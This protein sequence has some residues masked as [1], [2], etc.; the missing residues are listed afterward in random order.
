M[1]SI[2]TDISRTPH[3]DFKSVKVIAINL[4]TKTVKR[5][6]SVTEAKDHFK[7]K[8]TQKLC[9]IL[10]SDGLYSYEGTEY[11]FEYLKS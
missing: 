7:F 4:S 8:N 11:R 3:T 6:N 10:K 1:D 2:Q 9:R 5:F